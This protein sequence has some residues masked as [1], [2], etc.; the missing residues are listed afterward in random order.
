MLRL[1]ILSAVVFLEFFS[2]HAAQA[3]WNAGGTRANSNATTW[4]AGTAASDGFQG[5]IVPWIDTQYGGA[6][7][8]VQ[9]VSESGNV[10]WDSAGVYASYAGIRGFAP[11][12][13]ADGVGGAFIVFSDV[14]VQHVSATGQVLWPM[15]GAVLCPVPNGQYG[16]QIVGDGSGGA[17]VAWTDN[18]NNSGAVYA[19][20]VDAAGG[21]QWASDGIPV[22]ATTDIERF[23]SILS[24]GDGG[25][26]IAY[27]R[28][29]DVYVQRING[30]GAKQWPSGGVPLSLADNYQTHPQLAPDGAGGVVAAWNDARSNYWDVYAQ[31]INGSG[32]PQWV[33]DGVAVTTGPSANESELEPQIVSDGNGGAI[34][35]WSVDFIMHA[36]R[37]NASGALQWPGVDGVLVDPHPAAYGFCVVADGS[38][39]TF[40]AWEDYRSG[41]GDIYAQQINSAGSFHWPG[42][43]A[44]ST[45]PLEDS[46]PSIV[47]SGDGAIVAWTSTQSFGA[48]TY[49]QRI[50]GTATSV[51]GTPRAGALSLGDFS[52]NPFASS[53]RVDVIMSR[54]SGATAEVFDV[55]GRRV[56]TIDLGRIHAG[57]SQ[58]SFDGLDDNAHT[59][60]SG[61]YFY[62]VHT[63][64]Q[65]VTKKIVIAR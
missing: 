29:N 5:V 42:G 47:R 37:V 60:P 45:N 22:S 34:A 19:Q 38:G 36:Q 4:V 18:P 39:G 43:L 3:A 32:V 62:R 12:A 59:L 64:A 9:R 2:P 13:A 14:F 20:R 23:S 15:P 56:R 26:F 53:T 55:S 28:Q 52:P 24:D 48:L 40:V 25:A 61:V 50:G 10:Q 46:H 8:F 7:I 11:M 44:V 16:A 65:T 49:A 33:I 54:A 58:L 6:S 1:L 63:A 57:A 31:R 27:D 41:Y 35:V 21:V 17:I 51:R 30:D